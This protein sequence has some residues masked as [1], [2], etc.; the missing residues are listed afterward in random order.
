MGADPTASSGLAAPHAPGLVPPAPD[1]AGGAEA[2]PAADL[3]QPIGR[4]LATLVQGLAGA[5]RPGTGLHDALDDRPTPAD[6]YGQT[7]A[8]LALLLA[9]GGDPGLARTALQAWLDTP[10][11]RLDHH[12]FNRLALLAL[13]HWG[14]DRLDAAD[15][16]R[17]AQGLARC[18]LAAHY[19]SNN[20]TLLADTCRLLA[21]PAAGR[22]ALVRRLDQRLTRWTTAAGGFIDYPARPADQICVPA[23]YHHKALFLAAL[24]SRVTGDDRLAR[25]A[26]RLCDWLVH[27]WDHAGYAGG[28]GRSHQALFGDA[29]LMAGLLLLGLPADGPPGRIAERL[30]RRQQRPDQLFWLE[31]GG[32]TNGR[33]RWDDYMHLSV[34][35]AWAGALLALAL[36]LCARLPLP[37]AL[38]AGR[39]RGDE[40]GWHHDAQAGIGCWRGADGRVAVF[41]TIGQPPQLFRTGMVDLRGAGARPVHVRL[42]G[43]EPLDLAPCRLPTAALQAAP[44]LAGDTPLAEVAGRLHAVDA[45]TLRRCAAD[46]AGVELALE[47]LGRPAEPVPPRGAWSRLVAGLDWRLLGG[48]LARRANLRRRAHPAVRAEARLSLRHGPQ[49]PAPQLALQ[50]V[51]HP[52]AGVRWLN[53]AQAAGEHVFAPAGADPVRG[54]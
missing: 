38:A 51:L 15:H 54:G 22:D 34:Y 49:D 26:W 43:G 28:W 7:S 50:W 25:Q 44:A 52:A 37:E 46:G 16:A 14:D 21:S 13:Q 42:G 2:D 47:G 35:N 41:S 45:W 32:A 27:C 1:R 5:I 3:A 20:W 19:P 17:L 31:P 40:A 24:A 11:A 18:P 48:R 8:A 36:R 6:H 23:A 53:P 10:A 9:P 33:A 4:L 30:L 39:W 29:C 12:P